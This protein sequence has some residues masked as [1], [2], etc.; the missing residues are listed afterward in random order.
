MVYP[1][2]VGISIND[3]SF[4]NEGSCIGKLTGDIL[5]DSL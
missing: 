2:Q 4:D 1:R 5:G 3:M